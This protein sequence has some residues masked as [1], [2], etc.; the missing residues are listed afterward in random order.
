MVSIL[1]LHSFVL[2][3][4]KSRR[5]PAIGSL[6]SFI[7]WVGATVLYPTENAATEAKKSDRCGPT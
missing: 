3:E 7:V 6:I 5:L 4:A 2:V 1:E